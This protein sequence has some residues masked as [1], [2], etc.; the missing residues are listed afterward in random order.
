LKNVGED[1]NLRRRSKK[2]RRSDAKKTKN[3]LPNSIIL[4]VG[5][6]ERLPENV[7]DSVQIM[8]ALCDQMPLKVVEF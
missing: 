7:G 3:E 5:V 1:S 4:C 2:S 8:T 6:A